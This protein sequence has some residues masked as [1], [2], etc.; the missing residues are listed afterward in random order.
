MKKGIIMEVRSKY[1][2]V[3][4][5]DGSFEKA[6]VADHDA[7]IGKE[8]RYEP[9]V[10]R[11]QF[12]SKFSIQAK[13]LVIATVLAFFIVTTINLIED[14][15]TYA[16]VNVEIN[17]SFEIKVNRDL[18]VH[19]VTALNKEAEPLA[20]E[21]NQSEKTLK[22]MLNDIIS[23]CESEEMIKQ[24]K[25][26]LIGVSYADHQEG[27]ITN[28]IKE[29]F[30]SYN[31]DWQVV[32]FR[33]PGEVREQ[34]MENRTSMNKQFASIIQSGDE[35]ILENIGIDEEKREMIHAFYDTTTKPKEM[36]IEVDIN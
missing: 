27:G 24:G 32:T 16:Y 9:Y 5:A 28:S 26:A 17:P 20:R 35:K 14:T 31:T 19:E 2:I 21:L 36:I 6:V 22:E 3:L 8:V 1:V 33:V 30:Q 11:P 7:T 29:Y 23:S 13:F 18:E 4:T 25:R 12:P 10:S 34:A 15:E